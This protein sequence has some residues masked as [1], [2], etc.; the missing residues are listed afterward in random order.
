[1]AN[2]ML[3]DASHVEETRVVVL[4]D[5]RVE[6]LD[7]E[8]EHKKQIKGNIYLAKVTRVEPSLQAAFVDYG[9]NRHGFLPFLEIHPDYYQIPFSDRQALLK[10]SNVQTDSGVVDS[11][12]VITD[13]GVV[14][15]DIAINDDVNSVEL[16]DLVEEL[17]DVASTTN[18]SHEICSSDDVVFDNENVEVDS[19]EN[20]SKKLRRQYCIQ[21]VIKNRQ[22]LLVQ[23]VKEERG[24]KGAA[25]T[26]YLSL[27]GRY[28]V[29]MP[30]T[31]KGEAISRKVTNPI[32]RNNLKEIARTLEVPPGMGVI[33]RTAGAS[34]TKIE[35]KRDFEYL[36]RLWDN[37]R[38]FALNS[39]APHLVYEEGSLIKRAIRDL[40]SKDVTEIIVSGEKGYREAKDFMKLL[41][42]SYAKIVRQYN[43]VHPIFSH[44]G[45]EAQ[46]DCL[47]H[48]EVTL[49]S[50]GY[51]IIN[52][53]EA[54]VA[55]D[56]NS[57]RSTR[58]HSIE[59]TAFQTNLEASEEIARQ[60]RLRDLAGLIVVDFIDM[61][62]KRNNRA[63]EK[64]LKDSL[65][66]DR[67]RVQVGSISHFGL[68][69][70]SRQRIRSSVLEST[71]KICSTCKGSGYVRSQSSITLSIL[72]SI[73]EYLLEYT[74]HNIIVHT[75]PD[76]V[77]Y[78]LNQ[79]R[80]TIVEYESRF[81]VSIN[82]VIGLS[83]ADK[84]FNIEKG[85]PVQCP[86][87]IE[88]I[89]DFSHVQIEDNKNVECS[90]EDQNVLLPISNLEKSGNT[91]DKID[92]SI[93]QSINSRN[94]EG[95]LDESSGIV[96]KRRRRRRR[97]RPV[98]EHSDVVASDVLGSITHVVDDSL[99]IQDIESAH[100]QN[101][102]LASDDSPEL[103]A[104]SGFI[105]NSLPITSET[106]NNT[107]EP[108]VR[109][110]GWW[111]RRK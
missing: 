23:V 58:E 55:I 35:I 25:V 48:T 63:V 96:R 29:L 10:V 69:E 106:D 84:L 62:E 66:K 33:L 72:R 45:I 37:V 24:N 51:I 50:R 68:L 110:I 42:P 4:R 61:E 53:T 82:V 19:S 40:Y 1:M 6:D 36:M 90:Q 39:V 70:M 31:P 87:K 83:L 67:A 79:K 41:M 38:E 54:L 52:Q 88:H 95:A 108:V 86:V 16:D 43:D 97:R 21:E 17:E 18:L 59:S 64:K 78:L 94:T 76:F 107:S 99:A 74:T 20:L 8:S 73:E 22:I 111:R 65:K 27:A 12:V 98:I 46:L 105:P 47:H 13:S 15:S 109:K 2:K 93:E 85:S 26:T 77:L 3:I 30:N 91:Q 60:L 14:D 89:V 7:F 57:G 49:P 80:A 32:D 101:Q 5:N 44:S 56:V 81:G 92:D 104:E 100:I 11:D 103:I 102:N 9:G 71:T 28:S 75:H 34:R